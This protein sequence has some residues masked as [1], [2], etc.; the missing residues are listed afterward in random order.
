M[1]GAHTP[2]RPVSA[3]AVD[4]MQFLGAMNAS[5]FV[6]CGLGIVGS[7]AVTKAVLVVVGVANLSQFLKDVHAH[8]SGRWRSRLAIITVVDASFAVACLSL[9][10]YGA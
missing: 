5:I 3:V 9:L 10:L 4:M 2:E 8:A 7:P 6:A 1:L